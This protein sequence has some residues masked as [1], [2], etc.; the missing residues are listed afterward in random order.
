MEVRRIED[1]VEFLD[2]A[3]PRLLADEARHNLMLGL[4]ATLRDDPHVYPEYRLWLVQDGIT[5]VGAAL[6]TPPF[7]LVVARPGS[8]GV[9]SALADAIDE[10]LPGVGGALPES[11]TF[12]EVWAAKTGC[13]TRRVMGLGVYALERVRPVSGVPGAL[14]RA[15]EDDRPLL[16]EWM[17]AFGDEALPEGEVRGEAESAVDHRLHSEGAGLVLWE[18]DGPVSVAGYGGRTPNGVRIGPVYTPPELRGR[19]YASALVAGLSTSLLAEGRRFCF[20]FTDLAN[21]TSNRIY[22]RIGYE[23]VCES[24]QFAFSGSSAP[25]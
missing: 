11:E 4:A 23:R 8:D 20:L 5:P 14:R 7:N 19:G 25:R 9:L 16:I 1:P 13:A 2:V 15:G 6:R 24:A 22:E 12:A 18:D 21:P 17:R 10:E 3:G